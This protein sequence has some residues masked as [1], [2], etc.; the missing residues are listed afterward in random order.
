M[1]EPG[2]EELQLAVPEGVRSDRADKLMARLYPDLSRSRWQKLFQSGRVWQ[3]DR[4]LSQDDRLRPGDVVEFSIPPLEPLELR[5]VAMDLSVL[6][7]D[8]EILLID[9][10]PGRV[11]HP[12]AGTGD[13]T[14]VHGILH[15]CQG[16]LSGIGGKERPGIVHRLDKETSGVL[17]VAKSDAAFASLAEQFSGRSIRKFYTALVRGVPSAGAGSIDEP[18][19]RHPVHRLRMTC[20]P[21][22]RT[23]QTDYEVVRTWDRAAAQVWLQIHTG[24]TH[25]IR[26]HMKDLGHPLL[27]DSLYGYRDSFGITGA[28]IVLPPVPR[29]MLHATRLE[30]NHPTT[31]EAMRIESP[32]PADFRLVIEELDRCFPAV[33]SR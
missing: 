24:R 8:S 7:E 4:V 23:A 27:G 9:K 31:G 14:L 2:D 13:D 29:I 6:F 28:R 18:I 26:V 25:Q 11:V 19:G 33:E 5:P 30:F 21:D 20:R 32:L 16:S 22:G 1:A 3:E 12:G 17:I 15:H 10:E